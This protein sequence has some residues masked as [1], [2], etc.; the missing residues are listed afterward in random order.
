MVR[1]YAPYHS[2]ISGIHKQQQQQQQKTTATLHLN[3]KVN[4]RSFD[5]KAEHK[6]VVT[7]L[8]S[9]CFRLMD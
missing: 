7:I 9:V 8:P 2:S 3:W 1:L 6:I 4:Y 5:K